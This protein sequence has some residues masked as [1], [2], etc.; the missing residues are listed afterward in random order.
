MHSAIFEGQVKH[1]RMTPVPHAFRYRLFM[2]YLDL[3]ELDDVFESRWLWSARRWAIAR[4]RRKDHYGSPLESLDASIRRCVRDATG[5]SPEGGI[6]LL[7]QL[8]YFGYCFNPVSFYYCYDVGG[9]RLQAIVAEVNNTP[10]GERQMYVLDAHNSRVHSNE[11]DGRDWQQLEF[12]PK[13]AMHVSPFMAMNVDYR[14]RF[15]THDERVLIHMET[16]KN[17]AAIFTATLTLTRTEITGRAL[18]RVLLSYPLMTLKIIAAIHWQALRLWV[19]RAP[20]YRHP[21]TSSA[22]TD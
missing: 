15:S 14:W 7:T 2:M 1:R 10:W 16:A 21:Q 3:A 18:A 22:H 11:P 17:A 13:K 5:R 4:F 20:V 6:R 19:K 9:K 8:S 12:T